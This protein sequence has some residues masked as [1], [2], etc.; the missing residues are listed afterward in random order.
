MKLKTHKTVGLSLL[1]AILAAA[2]AAFGAGPENA[3]QGKFSLPVEAQWRHFIVPAGDYTF[4]LDR[5][6]QDAI[7]TLRSENHTFMILH[8]ATLNYQEDGNSVLHLRRVNGKWRVMQLDLAPVGLAFTYYHMPK[9]SKAERLTANRDPAR[10]IR[11]TAQ[12]K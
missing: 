5:V 7:L 3:C 8:V 11:V 1:F 4:T 12:R 6:T 2:L 10:T 9:E